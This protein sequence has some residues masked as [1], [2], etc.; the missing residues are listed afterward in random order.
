M[1]SSRNSPRPRVHIEEGRK[2]FDFCTGDPVMY[3]L[4]CERPIPGFEPSSQAAALADEVLH[5]QVYS[6]MA[7]LGIEDEETV[8]LFVAIT[9]WD[10]LA[11][12]RSQPGWRGMATA[13]GSGHRS[14]PRSCRS[15]LTR[16]AVWHRSPTTSVGPA[17]H[18]R[19]QQL[20]GRAATAALPRANRDL[21]AIRRGRIDV[22]FR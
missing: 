18:L 4:M 14:I 22:S 19:P 16:L 11:A 2:F 15:D 6:M 10:R 9:Q 7:N 3:A 8:R 20:A 13:D 21:A 5:I 1:R 12:K 17:P